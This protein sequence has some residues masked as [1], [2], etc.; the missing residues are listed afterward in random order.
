M[1]YPEANAYVSTNLHVRIMAITD[2]NRRFIPGWNK[3]WVLCKDELKNLR[4]YM[5]DAS[6]SSLLHYIASMSGAC[7]KE[8]VH[9][10]VPIILMLVKESASGI[11]TQKRILS[12]AEDAA[13][14][15]AAG[16]KDRERCYRSSKIKRSAKAIVARRV[17][18]A[19]RDSCQN[20]AC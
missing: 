10:E 20:K 17:R 11:N 2:F 1:G 8:T 3:S 12:T 4:A 18:R 9:I 5:S 14:I 6:E 16:R 7:N 15:P 19:E 13:H